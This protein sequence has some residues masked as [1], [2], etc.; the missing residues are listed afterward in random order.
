MSADG[1]CTGLLRGQHF[2]AR[3]RN[4]PAPPANL[5]RTISGGWVDARGGGWS[6]LQRKNTQK[7]FSS[8]SIRFFN[9]T[10]GMM[11]PGKFV[12]VPG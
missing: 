5:L 1:G 10:S 6:A 4:S 7:H 8:N 3:I 2:N 9:D 12:S 11:T